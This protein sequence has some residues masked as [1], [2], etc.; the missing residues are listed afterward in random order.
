MAGQ[1][2]SRYQPGRGLPPYLLSRNYA[3]SSTD[4]DGASRIFAESSCSMTSDKDS[5]C[6]S[7]S[8]MSCTFSYMSTSSSFSWSDTTSISTA[9]SMFEYQTNNA[10]RSIDE[11]RRTLRDETSLGNY[12]PISANKASNAPFTTTV[13]HNS[14]M[15]CLL[16]GSILSNETKKYNTNIISDYDYN[17]NPISHPEDIFTPYVPLLSNIDNRSLHGRNESFSLY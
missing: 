9:P 1:D 8:H 10:T 11:D 6:S 4:S 12:G 15:D 3:D 5:D 16:V 14:L 2:A 17:S 13:S 7:A